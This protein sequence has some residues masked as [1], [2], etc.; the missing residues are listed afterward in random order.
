MILRIADS[1]IVQPA[2]KKQILAF[3]SLTSTPLSELT[4]EIIKSGSYKVVQSSGRRANRGR[5][6]WTV[7]TFSPAFL[8]S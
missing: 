1:I 3:L 2:V 7:P 6:R 5:S 4:G 8:S